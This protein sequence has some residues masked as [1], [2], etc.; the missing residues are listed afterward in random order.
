MTGYNTLRRAQEF[1]NSF[2][3][4]WKKVVVLGWNFVSDIGQ[5][6]SSLDDKNLEVLVIPPDLL[7]MLKT[8]L[9][10]GNLSNL[11]RLDFFSPVSCC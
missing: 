7:D 3:G 8:K 10:T 5:I 1:R 9:N 6:I 11:A 4:G 2:A